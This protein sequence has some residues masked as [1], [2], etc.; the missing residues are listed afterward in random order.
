MTGVTLAMMREK[1]TAAAVCDALDALGFRDQS[2]RVPLR[3][4][5]V[6]GVLIGRCRTTC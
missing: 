4:L 5:T 3:P 1:L 6:L 2:P